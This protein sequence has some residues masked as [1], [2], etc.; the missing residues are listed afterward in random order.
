LTERR[1]FR[2]SLILD[3]TKWKHLLTFASIEIVS[4]KELYP[5]KRT[6]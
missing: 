2:F 5:P 6:M 3:G 4:P 1:L